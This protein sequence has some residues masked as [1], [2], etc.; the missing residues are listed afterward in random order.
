MQ[1]AFVNA[2]GT[3]CEI[4]GIKSGIESRESWWSVSK[5]ASESDD[6][7]GAFSDYRHVVR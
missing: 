3:A 6:G 1:H 2:T 7:M 5:I 4:K